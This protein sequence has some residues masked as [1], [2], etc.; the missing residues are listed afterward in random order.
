MTH[1]DASDRDNARRACTAV[2]NDYRTTLVEIANALTSPTTRTVSG[3]R[4]KIDRIVQD[5]RKRVDL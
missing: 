2:R 3:L 4:D 1:A 5:A